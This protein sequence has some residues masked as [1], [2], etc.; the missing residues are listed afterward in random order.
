MAF[1]PDSS[2]WRWATP[3]GIPYRWKEGSTGSVALEDAA[4][5]GIYIID[6]ANLL[7]FIREVFPAPIVYL[8]ILV[9]PST[10]SFPGFPALRAKT[11]SWK[12]LVDGMPIDPFG[13]DP[14]APADTY[15]QF[16]E[17]TIGF[18]TGPVN[19]QTESDPGDPYTFLE[20]SSNT[21]VDILTT[22]VRGNLE[23]VE[24]VVDPI[25]G[26]VTQNVEPVTEV[27]VNSPL[28]EVNTEWSVSWSQIPFD[29]YELVL[30]PKLR[31]LK[32][33]VN[34]AIM[35]VFHDAPIESIL[36]AGYSARN[37]HT[38]REG[39]AGASPV[40][41]D[42]VFVEKN[43]E[44]SADVRVTHNH[45]Y[46]PGVGYRKL[47]LDGNPLYKLGDLNSIFVS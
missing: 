27:D 1:N 9:R 24:D 41:V 6:S 18:G 16:L 36:F 46:R 3:G 12:S 40:T 7:A 42:F 31:G 11:V 43:F 19:D 13:N 33:N 10:I 34:N 25:T 14:T 45:T 8:G 22:N 28:I 39:Y 38:W 20:I 4:L 21:S 23:W 5:T 29:W 44:D 32:G 37:N 26:F 15:C 35:P 30:H 47:E 17:V 2:T